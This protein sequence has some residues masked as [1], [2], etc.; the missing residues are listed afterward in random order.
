MKKLLLM[1]CAAAAALCANAYT[2][3]FWRGPADNPIWDT[4]TAN[5]SVSS[6]GAASTTFHNNN[7]TIVKFDSLDLAWRLIHDHPRRQSG[8]TCK[9]D[10]WQLS[11]LWKVILAH[12]VPLRLR[13]GACYPIARRCRRTSGIYVF[14]NCTKRIPGQN[15]FC[16][17]SQFAF[18][19]LCHEGSIV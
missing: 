14:L 10:F 13:V 6:S 3:F 5:W 16:A 7:D 19:T 2:T 18:R 8:Q 11:Q 12:R 9:Y 17:V 15:S 1:T 4:A